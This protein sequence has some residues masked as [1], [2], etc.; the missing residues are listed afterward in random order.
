MVLKAALEPRAMSSDPDDTEVL[1]HLVGKYRKR[2]L[3]L[4]H[5][6]GRRSPMSKAPMASR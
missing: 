1:A 2:G 5:A 3:K 6:V 4:E